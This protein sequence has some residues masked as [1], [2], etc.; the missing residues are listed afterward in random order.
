MDHTVLGRIRGTFPGAAWHR[1]ALVA[2]LAALY[3]PTFLDL[4]RGAGQEV[5][6]AHGPLILEISAVL[7]WRED[8][9]RF[10]G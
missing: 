6:L 9:P 1:L 5:E 7:A 8:D 3:V 2:G 4:A 10:A